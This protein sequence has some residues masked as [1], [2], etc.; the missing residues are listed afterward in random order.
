MTSRVMHTNNI[1]QDN[2]NKVYC[3]KSHFR[4]NLKTVCTLALTVAFW[5]ATTEKL[6]NPPQMKDDLEKYVWSTPM[7]RWALSC[8][9]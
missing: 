8:S 5:G 4:R 6:L 2:R 1:E 7:R 3:K 9:V